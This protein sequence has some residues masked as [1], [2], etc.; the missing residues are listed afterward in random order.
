[1][2]KWFTAGAENRILSLKLDGQNRGAMTLAPA[3]GDQYVAVSVQAL[4]PSTR[5]PANYKIKLEPTE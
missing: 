3:Y 5:L 4:A 1:M 2:S